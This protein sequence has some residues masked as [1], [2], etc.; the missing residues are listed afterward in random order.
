MGVLFHYSTG[1]CFTTMNKY[2]SAISWKSRRQPT[3]ALSSTE[4]EYMGLSACTQEALYL[5]QL[6]KEIDP[7]FVIKFCCRSRWN[8]CFPIVELCLRTSTIPFD[9]V[10][11]FKQSID[12]GVIDSSLKKTAIVPVFKSG[13]RT[14]PSNYRPI[15]LTS[16]IIKVFERVI[17]KQIVTFLIS[18]GHL[19][20]TQHGFRGGRSCLS[21]L[22]SVFD[23]VMQLL[24]SGNNTVDM[25]YLDFAKAFDKVDHGVLL[26]KIKML[27]IT[28]KLG[29]WLITF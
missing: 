19:N 6:C 16:V 17:R 28:G 29:V 25:V 23:D 10:L 18:K 5:K 2:G 3:V 1:H 13:D 7:T 15:S 11:V 9:P 24:N 22:L 4:A 26:H 8:S 14:V 21:A 12:S 27:G 20:P